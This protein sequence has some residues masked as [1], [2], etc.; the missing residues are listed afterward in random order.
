[1]LAIEGSTS[2]DD[3]QWLTYWVLYSFITFFKLSFW[4]VLQWSSF[5]FGKLPFWPYLKLLFCMWLVLP[6]IN[7]AAYVYA[8]KMA[9]FLNAVA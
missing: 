1:M 6:R 3:Q 7:G 8:N 5:P 2:E 4:K 9:Y